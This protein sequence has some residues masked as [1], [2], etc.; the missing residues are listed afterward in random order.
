[1]G[2]EEGPSSISAYYEPGNSITPQSFRK[3]P[4]FKGHPNLRLT[5]IIGCGKSKTVQ[6]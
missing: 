1:M 2:S 6:S 3:F 4:A 5:S